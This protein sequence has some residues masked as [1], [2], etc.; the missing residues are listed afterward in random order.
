MAPV[1]RPG[2]MHGMVLAD[3][4][5]VNG[6]YIYNWRVALASAP[7]VYVKEAQTTKANLRA[8]DLT[9]GGIYNIQV[10]AVGAAGASDWSDAGN[11]T[12]PQRQSTTVRAVPLESF[13]LPQRK[14]FE[15]C[16]GERKFAAVLFFECRGV[17]VKRRG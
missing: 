4:G 12:A 8:E 15:E 14:F 5:A 11:I 2:F 7:T 13:P 16:R 3:T 9:R 10:S 1:V 6:A 17:C